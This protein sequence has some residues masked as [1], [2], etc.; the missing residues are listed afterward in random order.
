MVSTGRG[1]RYFE[2]VP[3][4]DGRLLVVTNV[5]GSVSLSLRNCPVAA[6]GASSSAVVRRSVWFGV[7]DLIHWCC[8]STVVVSRSALSSAAF[9]ASLVD[10]ASHV[11]SGRTA[12]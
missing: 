3:G 7:V 2:P 8:P 4:L 9:L 6:T 5:T 1:S 11:D 10:V 12:N